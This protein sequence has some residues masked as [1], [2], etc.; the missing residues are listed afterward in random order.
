MRAYAKIDKQKLSQPKCQ[1]AM[2]VD[3]LSA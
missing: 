2:C 1:L 3:L